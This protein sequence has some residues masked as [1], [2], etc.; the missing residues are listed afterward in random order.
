MKPE[1]VYLKNFEDM[2]YDSVYLLYFACD[3][4]QEKYADNVISPFVRTS[5]IN[6]ILLIECAANCAIASLD[7]NTSYFNEIE[8][9]TSLGKF[10]FFLNNISRKS[11]DRGSLEVQRIQELKSIR[12]Y[13]VHPKVR[14]SVWEQVDTNLWVVDS[15]R[16]ATLQISKNPRE[17][18]IN[19]AIK[20][21]KSV[22][23]F[24]NLYF[25]DWCNLHSDAVY[26]ILIGSR[27]VNLSAPEGAYV[28]CVGGLDRAYK[29]W[30]IDFRFL[31]K[32]HKK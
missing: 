6:S 11:I 4:D 22:N 25:L 8:R 32:I 1:E 12:D 23:D 17:W 20:A 29:N 14:K 16:T 27:K 15:G 3:T 18:E 24:F 13:Y 7:L 10:E 30:G 9:L 26:D 21:L 19:D 28:D 2:L 31:G 5:L